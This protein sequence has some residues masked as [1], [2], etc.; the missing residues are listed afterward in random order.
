VSPVAAQ[1]REKENAMKGPQKL[2]PEE[3][4]DLDARLIN[5]A[6]RGNTEIV[7][8]LVGA[9]ADVH[10]RNDHALSE[11]AWCGHAQTVQT[12][13]LAGA[14]V[15]A[16]EDK[17]LRAAAWH[18]HVETVKILLAAGADIHADK[19][20]AVYWAAQ[21]G[22]TETVK[23]L[24]AAGADVHKCD[25][26][27]LRLAAEYGHTETVRVL[28]THIFA[29]DSWRG[30]SRAEI[31][32]QANALYDKVKAFNIWKP[33]EPEDLRKAAAILADSALTC[34][35]QVRP[36]PPK[37]QVSPLPAQPRAL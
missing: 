7:N 8:V 23:V 35:E 29:P 26:W 28:V 6:E 22:H 33:I 30:K 13:L 5:A 18:G 12:L 15:H 17:A 27:P 2:P 32:T 9:G 21:N 37:I 10:V 11:A 36:A 31:E 19:D 20:A 24:L 3:Q 25:D 4:R 14:D 1:R 34:W 16:D